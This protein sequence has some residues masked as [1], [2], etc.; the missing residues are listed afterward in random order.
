MAAPQV[1]LGHA[2]GIP[3]R[4][5]SVAI[6]HGDS[7]I[8]KAV[9]HMERLVL[10]PEG[11][12]HPNVRIA[13]IEAAHGSVKNVNEIDAVFRWVKQNIEFRGEDAETLQSPAVTLQLKAGDCDD[14]SIL[15]A[16]LLRSLGYSVRF[17]TVAAN[18]YVPNQFT[19]VYAVVLDKRTK[20]WIPLDTTVQ[21]SFPGWE[22]PNIHRE[23]MYVRKGLGQDY[24]QLP[25]YV[26]PPLVP[27]PPVPA[28]LGP[29]GQFIYDLTSPFAQALASRIAH[30]TTPAVT[31]NLNLGVW[32]PSGSGG[33]PTWI[34]VLLGAGVLIFVFRN[35]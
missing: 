10:G 2:N 35:R 14:H 32:G 33:L 15:M 5:R 28:G 16:A 22:P 6:G 19:H 4:M 11:V 18:S 3:Y 13:A 17:K 25:Q 24:S 23:N 9:L 8:R 21:P 20:Q 29:K 34:W 7:A 12:G 1:Q 30:G 27:A 31:G 26:V